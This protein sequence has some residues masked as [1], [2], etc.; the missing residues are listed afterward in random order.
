M[1]NFKTDIFVSVMSGTGFFGLICLIFHFATEIS[2]L[3]A[4]V[5]Y[6]IGQSK[7]YRFST[8]QTT[9]LLMVLMKAQRPIYFDGYKIIYCKMDTLLRVKSMVY[10]L[11]TDTFH[12]YFCH[13]FSV[14]Q[15]NHVVLFDASAF[16]VNSYT[17]F[18]MFKM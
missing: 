8:Q 12:L 18:S 1:K 7:W 11:F 3:C 5:E 2:T 16:H 15:F 9:C 4:E 17:R 6:H 10:D 13:L 14:D